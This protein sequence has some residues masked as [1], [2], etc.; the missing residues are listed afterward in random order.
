[1]FITSCGKEPIDTHNDNPQNVDSVYYINE[2]F[3]M[4]LSDKPYIIDT[5]VFFYNGDSL[6]NPIYRIDSVILVSD[7]R[8]DVPACALCTGGFVFFVVKLLNS[9]TN[10]TKQ[11]TLNYPGCTENYLS[12]YGSSYSPVYIDSNELRMLRVLPQ[13]GSDS[14]HYVLGYIPISDYQITFRFQKQP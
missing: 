11:D 4:K 9:E 10:I 8:C 2:E 3:E 5:T 7:E 1:M 12:G 13:P 14:M 6:T